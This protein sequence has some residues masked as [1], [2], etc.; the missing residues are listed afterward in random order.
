MA[1]AKGRFLVACP[2]EVAI[3]IRQGDVL[4]RIARGIKTNDRFQ[5][6]AGVF[7]PFLPAIDLAERSVRVAAVG[8]EIE[9]L[10]I[11][12]FGLLIFPCPEE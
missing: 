5:V 1:F 6:Y 3:D 2:A 9:Q 12:A 10:G 7:P 4:S 8:I 11:D